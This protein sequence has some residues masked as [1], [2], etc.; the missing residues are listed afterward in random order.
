VTQLA[1]RVVEQPSRPLDGRVVLLTG[2]GRGVGAA[3]ALGLVGA[4]AKVAVTSRSPEGCDDVVAAARAAGGEAIPLT[5]DLEAGESEMQSVVDHVVDEWGALHILVNNAGVLRPHMVVKITP[6]ELD[7]MLRVNF[8]RPFELCLAALPHLAVDGGCIVNISA[9]SATRAQTGMGG[10][11]AS[12]AAM[13]SMTRN[14]AREW[15]PMG[16]RVNAIVPGAIATDMILP[17]DVSKRDEFMAQMGTL[18]ALGRIAMPD[19]LVGP[20]VFLAS[21]ASRFVTGQALFVDGGA[22]E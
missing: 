20:V 17:R 2:G 16:V 18:N 14:M 8:R 15:G 5:L 10:Y 3:V 6:A 22:F 19:D 11:A 7:Q 12:K 13:L 21:D 1:S 9:L 4:G